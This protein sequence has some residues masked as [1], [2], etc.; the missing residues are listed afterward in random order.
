MESYDIKGF[1]VG[2]REGIHN[3]LKLI[4]DV[5]C[6]FRKVDNMGGG[7]AKKR[8]LHKFVP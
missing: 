6:Q 7:N 2:T 3:R 5:K 8:K 1:R 4:T